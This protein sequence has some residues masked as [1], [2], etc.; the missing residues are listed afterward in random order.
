MHDVDGY[1]FPKAYVEDT[2][3][4]QEA[5]L[6]M[7]RVPLMLRPIQFVQER[8]AAVP[9]NDHQRFDSSEQ[10]RDELLG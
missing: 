10:A 1:S 8:C 3:Y 7:V 9:D 5:M 2:D 6:V 4:F